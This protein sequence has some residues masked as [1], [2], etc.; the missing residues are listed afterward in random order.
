MSRYCRVLTRAS[1]A[2]GDNCARGQQRGELV[3]RG[4]FHANVVQYSDMLELRLFS[5]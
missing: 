2:S 4:G 3:I 1:R 5:R